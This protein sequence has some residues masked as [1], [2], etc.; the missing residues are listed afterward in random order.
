MISIGYSLI[1]IGLLSIEFL[2]IFMILFYPSNIELH[3][4]MMIY[5]FPCII[6]Y[7]SHVHEFSSWFSRFSSRW[8]YDPCFHD[9][10]AILI[11]MNKLWSDLHDKLIVGTQAYFSWFQVKGVKH[12]LTCLCSWANPILWYD[13]IILYMIVFKCLPWDIDLAPNCVI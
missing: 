11:V 13:L 9:F 12:Q 10:N 1:L 6:W 8:V 2:V 3:V 5:K 7:S 4:F